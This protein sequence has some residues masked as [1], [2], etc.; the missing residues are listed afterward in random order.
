MA[1][2]PA[3]G[4]KILN[5][6]VIIIP[7]AKSRILF[8][9]SR[10]SIGENHHSLSPDRFLSRACE[11][12]YSHSVL[13]KLFTVETGSAPRVIGTCPLGTVLRSRFA[14]ARSSL[15]IPSG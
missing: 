13:F 9:R 6:K 5:A 12:V 2:A 10:S 3:V 8:V 11:L 15:P 1:C 4:Q 14:V 7:L